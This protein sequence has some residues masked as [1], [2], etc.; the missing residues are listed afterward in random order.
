MR[1]KFQIRKHASKSP[2]YFVRFSIEV[3]GKRR[4]VERSTRETDRRLAIKKAEQIYKAANRQAERET[5]GGAGKELRP[6]MVRWLTEVRTTRSADW[7][8]KLGDYAAGLWL[9]RWSYLSDI[10][11]QTLSAYVSDRLSGGI[12]TVTLRKEKSGLN[13][14][15]KWCHRHGYI[16]SMPVWQLPY[17]KSDFVPCVVTPKEV[18]KI[19]EQLEEP[20]RSYYELMWEYGF[21]RG[22]MA[23]LRW[24]DVDING[25][26]LHIR[27]GADKRMYARSLPI[28]DRALAVF[29]RMGKTKQNATLFPRKDYQR[30]QLEQAVKDAGIAKHVTNHTFR[31]SRLTDLAGKTKDIVSLQ[32]VAG[33]KTLLSTQRY[34][35]GSFDKAKELLG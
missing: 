17:G 29:E 21:R 15:L 27:A 33:H 5:A 31:H 34:L 32:Y 22:T 2:Y 28:T 24:D 13:M 10:D 11:N 23:R 7:A 4:Q 26:T 20:A 25:R 16:K 14:F 18:E 19:L 30:P 1:S 6:L 3:G 8:D 9:P 12:S 35:H